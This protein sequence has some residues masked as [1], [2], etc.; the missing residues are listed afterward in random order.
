MVAYP[1]RPHGYPST[2][3]TSTPASPRLSGEARGTMTGAG[4]PHFMPG[5]DDALGIQEGKRRVEI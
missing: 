2:G 1:L 5:L 3:Y 4:L